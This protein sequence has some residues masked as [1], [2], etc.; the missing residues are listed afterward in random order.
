MEFEQKGLSDLPF[1]EQRVQEMLK[2]DGSDT[3]HQKVREYLTAY[4]NDTARAAMLKW[5]E[6]GDQFLGMF[7]GGF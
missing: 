6:L 2:S 4:T 5:W 3:G 7:S 1:V